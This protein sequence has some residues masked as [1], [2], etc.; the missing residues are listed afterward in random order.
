MNRIPLRDHADPLSLFERLRAL[1]QPVLLHSSDRTSAAGRYDAM[2]AD[3]IHSIIY[4][5]GVLR[6]GTKSIATKRPL[7][8]LRTHFE[9]SANS[10][11]AHFRTGF[12]GYFGYGLHHT[13]ELPPG[14]PDVTGLPQM[15][16]GDYS[17]SVV[18]GRICRPGSVRADDLCR[19]ESFANV[20]H[21]VSTIRGE[22][23]DGLD[24][25]DVRE[26]VF[27]GGSITGAPKIRA[28][29]IINA[30][31]PVA[32][33]VYCG[34]LGW[35]DRSGALDTNIAIR[36]LAFTPTGVHAWGGGGIVADSIATA[37]MAEIDHKI[38]RLLQATGEL[39]A[40]SSCSAP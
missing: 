36:T 23:I 24:A 27:P 4:H 5:D 29:Q 3:P 28:M 40:S 15:C 22:I 11:P 25:W 13:L 33:S 39:E 30:L 21:L 2:A 14:P 38:G 31:E 9:T 16:G 34:S 6:V 8:A 19:F 17:W 35:I 1:P 10:R 26:A 12:I 37:E 20:H 32:R 7:D 18:T